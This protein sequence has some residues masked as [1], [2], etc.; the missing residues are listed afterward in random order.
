MQGYVAKLAGL[1]YAGGSHWVQDT[2]LQSRTLLLACLPQVHL[3]AYRLDPF[4]MCLCCCFI[5]KYSINAPPAIFVRMCTRCLQ[6]LRAQLGPCSMNSSDSLQ[7]LLQHRGTHAMVHN[8]VSSIVRK[9]SLRQALLGGFTAG[10]ARGFKY[11]L[12]KGKK[13]WMR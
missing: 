8:A 6:A 12:A 10:A 11:L 4:T 1:R 7:R 13:R 9:S 2:S 5:C 3:V